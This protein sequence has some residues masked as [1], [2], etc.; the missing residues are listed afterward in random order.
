[1]NTIQS[2]KLAMAGTTRTFMDEK[3]SIW[4]GFKPI[5]DTIDQIDAIVDKIA[6]AAERQAALN[7]TAPVKVAARV[8]LETLALEVAGAICAWATMNNKPDIAAQSNITPTDLLRG[9]PD[10][11]AARCEN[12]A[13]LAEENLADLADHEI[14][15]AIIQDLRDKVKAFRAAATKPRAHRSES[16]A[17]TAALKA[18]FEQLDTLLVNQ[19]DKLMV[20]YQSRDPEFYSAY[21]AARTIVDVPGG[22]ASAAPVPLTQPVAVAVHA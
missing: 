13:T 18:L 11:I 10:Q 12:I 14:T 4:T 9:R 5:A 3:K 6:L 17:A 7:G 1:M 19:L 16:S 8:A 22:R 15:A 20:R 2:N 21:L